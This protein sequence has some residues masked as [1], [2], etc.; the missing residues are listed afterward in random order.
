[1]KTSVLLTAL[2]LA[3]AALAREPRWG[4]VPAGV[5][6]LGALD[7]QEG[8]VPN[9]DSLATLDAFQL[10]LHEVSNEEFCEFL[11]S[12]PANCFDPRMEIVRLSSGFACI[13]GRQRHPIHHV[14][15]RAA[16]AYARWLGARLPSAAEW[17]AAAR[18]SA[19]PA[20]IYSWGNSSA[21]GTLGNCQETQ[22]AGAVFAW[23]ADTLVGP[24]PFGHLQLSGNLGE[25]TA[26]V[27][28]DSTLAVVKGGSW[29][30]PETNLRAA[31]VR[32]RPTAQGSAL[33][34]FRVARP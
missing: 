24:G 11:N 31:I 18:G 30:D 2:L 19:E 13:Q 29:A 27:S 20:R 7:S 15:W 17:E 33:I 28:A 12:G 22:R 14:S 25:W 23:P 16:Q 1:M 9:T 32:R 34:G 8:L 26:D 10:G 5:Y 4:A 6:R 21:A 3:G